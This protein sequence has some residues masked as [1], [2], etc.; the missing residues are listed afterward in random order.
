LN[1]IHKEEGNQ[2]EDHHVYY[3][4]PL[5]NDYLLWY[6]LFKN[7]NF[8]KFFEDI[9][10]FSKFMWG[11]DQFCISFIFVIRSSDGHEFFC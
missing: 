11:M 4:Q 6:K 1:L 7:S 8:L 2:E 5:L 10:C 3:K 9:V